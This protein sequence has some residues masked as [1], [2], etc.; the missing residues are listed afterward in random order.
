MKQGLVRLCPRC[1]Q[2]EDHASGVK[3]RGSKNSEDRCELEYEFWK[4]RFLG[5]GMLPDPDL[6]SL[7]A[8]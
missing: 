6:G 5:A 7:D 8:R 1:G 2:V 3:L 4:P